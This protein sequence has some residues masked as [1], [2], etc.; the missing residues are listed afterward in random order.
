MA[1]NNDSPRRTK[2]RNN[3]HSRNHTTPKVKTG[4]EQEEQGSRKE[5]I[6]E[7]NYIMGMGEQ[8]ERIHRRS[9]KQ[10]GTNVIRRGRILIKEDNTGFA[11]KN[12]KE[13]NN[14][15]N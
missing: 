6:H 2:G 5:R 3:P 14:N 8:Q 12:E 15:I 10:R 13:I 7:S 11:N 9:N 4:R 1:K